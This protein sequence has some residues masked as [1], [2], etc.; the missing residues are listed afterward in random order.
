MKVCDLCGGRPAQ[1]YTIS[2]E[3]EAL[4]LAPDLC[5][6]HGQRYLL[7][8]GRVLGEMLRASTESKPA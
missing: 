8:C 4:R 1:T 2:V 3:G 5:T 7:E 6:E